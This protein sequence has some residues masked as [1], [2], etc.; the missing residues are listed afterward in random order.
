MAKAKVSKKDAATPAAGP[1]NGTEGR[2]AKTITVSSDT[3]RMKFPT[4]HQTRECGCV[5]VAGVHY[6]RESD[7]SFIVAREHM[8]ALRHQG[9][10]PV[11]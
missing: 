5:S 11:S 9:L 6:R 10:E 8:H 2:P 3:V 7:G 4:E 1:A